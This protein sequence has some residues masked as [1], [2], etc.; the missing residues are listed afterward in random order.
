MRL[1][2]EKYYPSADIRQELLGS[3]L[4]ISPNIHAYDTDQ[5][6][7]EKAITSIKALSIPEQKLDA[8]TD[9]I[10]R[11]GETIFPT[12]ASLLTKSIKESG[13]KDIT[14]LS[15]G[16]GVEGNIEQKLDTLINLQREED[17]RI[18]WVGMDTYSPGKERQSF[19]SPT[20]FF[21]APPS[22][23]EPFNKIAQL[24]SSDTFFILANYVYHH[25]DTPFKDF[26]RRCNDAQNVFLLEE[27]I[28]NTKWQDEKYRYSRIAYDVLANVAVNK[29]WADQFLN[30]PNLFTVHYLTYDEAQDHGEI[31]NFENVFPETSLIKVPA[32]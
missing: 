9:R 6:L 4:E 20:D 31:I 12:Y 16:S 1:D 22:S 28:D 14:F 26:L 24:G 29:K 17:F 25:M 21:V 11:Q 7:V 13:A 18:R 5:E 23:T 32:L 27:P 10:F 15:V 30:N 3:I 8:L 19:F 2:L